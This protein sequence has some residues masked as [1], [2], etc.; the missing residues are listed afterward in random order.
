[1]VPAREKTENPFID[2]AKRSYPQSRVKEIR[3]D[4][5][6]Q[7]DVETRSQLIKLARANI[8]GTPK[9]VSLFRALGLE[10][11]RRSTL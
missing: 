8:E 9:S 4:F 3:L 6:S 1:M 10:R 5:E 11:Y 7:C 2:S